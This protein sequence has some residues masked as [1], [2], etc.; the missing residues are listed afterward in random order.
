MTMSLFRDI[1]ETTSTNQGLLYLS[2]MSVNS[3]SNLT[4][5]KCQHE[6]HLI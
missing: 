1:T 6:V 2:C 5:N 3:F 4:T